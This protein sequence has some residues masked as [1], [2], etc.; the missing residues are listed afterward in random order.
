MGVKITNIERAGVISEALPYIKK[1]TNK[2]VVVKYG[3]NAMKDE[4]IEK[5]V[6]ADIVL[7]YIIGVKVVLIHGGGPRMNLLM[8]K[9]GKKSEFIEGLRVTDSETIGVA[10]MVLAG[11][12]NKSLVNLL[13]VLGA[14]AIGISGID[15]GMVQ[16]DLKDQ[17]LGFVGEISN[18]DKKPITDLIENGYIPVVSTL[19]CDKEGVI[20]NING[21]SFATNVAGALMAERLIMM[22]NTEGILRDQADPKSLIT[23]LDIEEAESLKKEGIVS[24]GMIPKVTACIQAIRMG[25]KNCVIINGCTPHS[26][27]LELLTDEGA[28]TLIKS[29]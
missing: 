11:D 13:G 29:K 15:A 9:L 20:Y 21:D 2:I 28:G 17:K 1:Y 16:C 12:V 5:S 19:G 18:V 25:V 6:M 4:K 8:E 7:L 22:T 10:K 26:L 14:K 23:E 24:G 3:G 27:L